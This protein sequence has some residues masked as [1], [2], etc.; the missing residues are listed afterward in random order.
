MTAVEKSFRDKVDEIIRKIEQHEQTS[1]LAA[2]NLLDDVRRE[3]I[4]DLAQSGE[5]V[6]IST[7]RTIRAAIGIRIADFTR[8]LSKDFD[9]NLITSFTLGS[10]LVDEPAKLLSN[11]VYSISRETAAAAAEFSADLIKGLT[12]D[13]RNKI[14]GVI[15]RAAL[16]AISTQDAIAAVGRS[17]DDKGVFKTIAARAETIIRTEVLRI[18]S[19]ATHAR[20]QLHKDDVARAGYDFRK[21]WLNANDLRV[22]AAHVVAQMNYLL[23]QNPGPIP[24]DQMFIVDGEELIYPRDLRGSASNTV[25]CRCTSMPVITRLA[26]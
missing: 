3:T 9:A 26:S 17:L 22:R 19:I 16:G 21:G 23:T 18:Q 14:N 8:E 20:M 10:Q 2:L 7:A 4:A 12:D 25:H 1:I 15:R 5:I 24:V 6:T 11:T 13:L